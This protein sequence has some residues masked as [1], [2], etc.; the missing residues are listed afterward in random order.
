MHPNFIED[1]WSEID[2][3]YGNWYLVVLTAVLVREWCL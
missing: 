2:V 3:L 1:F